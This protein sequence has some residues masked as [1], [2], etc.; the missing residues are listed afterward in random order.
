VEATKRMEAMKTLLAT[1]SAPRPDASALK[2]EWAKLGPRIS[3]SGDAA[4]KQAAADAG[5][6]LGALVSQGK[7]AEAQTIIDQ[8][9]ARLDK[10]GKTPDAKVTPQDIIEEW[11]RLAAL[12]AEKAK[13]HPEAKAEAN[14]AGKQA[15]DLTKAGKVLEAKKVLDELETY[16]H[17]ITEEVKEKESESEE[18]VTVGKTETK[19]EEE[20]DEDEDEDEPEEEAADPRKK[21]YERSGRNLSPKCSWR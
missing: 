18:P 6:Q 11:K 2:A 3:A 17:G 9:T 20:E 12:V 1:P 10:A 14:K 8:L 16:L 15:Q 13:I 7:L 4:I 19:V 21:Q 5:K